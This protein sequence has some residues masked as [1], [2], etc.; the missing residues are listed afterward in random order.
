VKNKI[1]VLIPTSPIPA[2]PSTDVI[3]KAINSVRQHL[4]DV[5]IIIMAD[6]V[7]K[8]QEHY[9]DQYLEYIKNLVGKSI[10]HWKNIA[11]MP[12][13]EFMHQAAMTRKALEMVETPQILFVEHDTFFLD[14]LPIDFEGISRVIEKGHANMVGFH[15]QWEPWVIPEHEHLML[16]KERAYFDGVPMIRT[17]QWSQRPHVASA[18][19]YRMILRNLFSKNCRTMIEDRMHDVVLGTRFALGDAGWKEWKLMYYAPT[20]GGTIRRTWTVD[21]R[22]ADPKFPME[23]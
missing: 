10:F 1:T 6:G 11:L 13:T 4:P 18:E 22:G 7:R 20:E 19:F 8:E 21:G 2:H 14:G 3:E 16:D 9:H 5:R 23:F 15:C 17:W 12:F